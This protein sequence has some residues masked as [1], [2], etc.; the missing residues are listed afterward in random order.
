MPKGRKRVL[1]V[2]RARLY[3]VTPYVINLTDRRL[4]LGPRHAALT[5]DIRARG[6]TKEKARPRRNSA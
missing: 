6:R 4:T 5:V 3:H 1:P 2:G